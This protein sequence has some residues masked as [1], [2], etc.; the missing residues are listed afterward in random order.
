[1]TIDALMNDLQI[2]KDEIKDIKEINTVLMNKLDKAYDDRI[3]LRADN[4][5]MKDQLKGIAD[6]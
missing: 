1:M 6:A 2:M 5:S 3:E 4:Y